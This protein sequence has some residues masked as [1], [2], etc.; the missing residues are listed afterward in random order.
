MESEEDIVFI[1]IGCGY[2]MGQGQG[3]KGTGMLGSGEKKGKE[4]GKVLTY[5]QVSTNRE[6]K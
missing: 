6:G 4:R 3:S 2:R 5:I 1:Q